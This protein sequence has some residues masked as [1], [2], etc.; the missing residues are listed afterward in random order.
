MELADTS[1]KVVNGNMNNT[2]S[3]NDKEEGGIS[4]K[5]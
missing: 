4:N 2:R 5:T 1:K 3:E